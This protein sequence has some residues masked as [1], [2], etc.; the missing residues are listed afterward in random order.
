[1]KKL[2]LGSVA[3]IA[4]AGVHFAMAADN[5]V[6]APPSE[7]PPPPPVV[8]N[9]TGFYAGF[10]VG[11]AWGSYDPETSTTQGTYL[12]SPLDVA[13]INA[14]GPQSIKPL[15]FISGEQIGYNWQFDRYVAGLQAD[16][17]FLHLNGAAN[18]GAVPY[19]GGGPGLTCAGGVP[20]NQFV[21]SSY[22]HADWLATVQPKVGFLANNSLLY[23][24]GG[25]ALTKLNGDFLFTD[26]PAGP[27]EAG[28]SA[29]TSAFQTGYTV[30]GGVEAPISDRLSLKAEYLY[31]NFSD[32]LAGRNG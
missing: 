21:L 29:R 12:P 1:M 22:A 25:L 8:Y 23:V 20:K 15:G 9:W 31:V 32:V 16:F 27:C 30:G 17:N 2:L 6:K 7:P 5:N 28:Q 26:G 24:T 11:A 19:P 18:S 4:V 14:A 13:A 10:N 3:V